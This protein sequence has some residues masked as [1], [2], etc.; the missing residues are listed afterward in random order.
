M[1]FGDHNRF[2]IIMYTYV[3][4]CIEAQSRA[5]DG[6]QYK[7]YVYIYSYIYWSNAYI[8]DD[9]KKALRSRIISN[10]SLLCIHMYTYV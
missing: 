9:L 2:I 1:P 3:C 5:V 4:L 8:C 7:K 6:S 10:L